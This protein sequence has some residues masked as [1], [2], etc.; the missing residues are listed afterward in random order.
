VPDP[1]PATL[2][3]QAAIDDRLA[4]LAAEIT[5][6]FAGAQSL[7]LVGVLRGAFMFLAD[8]A[9]RIAL[10]TQVDFIALASYDDDAVST[11]EVRLVMDVRHPI[12]GRH[13]LIVEDI[14]DSGYTMD[15]LLK[16][17]AARRP[18]S[19][20]VC[21]M[22]RKPERLRLPVPIDYVGFDIPDV[23]VVGY[24]MD[25]GDRFRS[26]PFIGVLPGP[27]AA[28]DPDPA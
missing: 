22:L 14:V 8:L 13:V 19:L 1:K 25:L 11:G 15:Y 18:A 7:L 21:T 24:G 26:L 17:F 28:A 23:W 3:S 20:R 5:A 9:R 27:E 2:I 4:A 6:D 12:E 16:L 10:P